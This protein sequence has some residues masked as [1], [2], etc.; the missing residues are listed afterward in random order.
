LT[1][2]AIDILATKLRT[3]LQVRLHLTL[4]LEAGYQTGEK[5]VTAELVETVLSRQLDDME[6]TLVSAGLRRR[7]TSD[8]SA[9]EQ[10]LA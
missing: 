3:P 1:A 4:A 2:D 7:K 9:R 6:P 8:N 5:P 10:K